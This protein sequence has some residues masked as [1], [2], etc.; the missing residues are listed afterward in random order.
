MNLCDHAC[1]VVLLASAYSARP[2][3]YRP[4]SYDCAACRR[5]GS[6]TARRMTSACT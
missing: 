5:S 1:R 2:S 6:P 3:V 4:A